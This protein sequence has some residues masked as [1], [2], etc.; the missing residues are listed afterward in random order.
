MLTDIEYSIMDDSTYNSNNY[1]LF[2]SN[3]YFKFEPGNDYA[4]R[5]FAELLYL[6]LRPTQPSKNFK[7]TFLLWL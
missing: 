7:W 4:H 6:Y 2:L 5:T 3:P 1:V